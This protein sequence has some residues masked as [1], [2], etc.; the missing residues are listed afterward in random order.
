MASYDGFL[1]SN[2]TSISIRLCLVWYE[3]TEYKQAL[4]KQNHQDIQGSNKSESLIPTVTFGIVMPLIIM[5]D[6]RSKIAAF[7]CK[8]KQRFPR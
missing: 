2:V 4:D 7:I 8:K 1:L 6:L 3:W 5:L